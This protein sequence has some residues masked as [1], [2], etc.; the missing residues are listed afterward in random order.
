MKELL[1]AKEGLK[2]EGRSFRFKRKFL[3]IVLERKLENNGFIR[4]HETSVSKKPGVSKS[5][6]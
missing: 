1:K 2:R 3:A 4:K 6:N 5:E